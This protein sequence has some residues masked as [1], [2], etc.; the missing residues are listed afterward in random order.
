MNHVVFLTNVAPGPACSIPE[1]KKIFRV[2]D[3]DVAD[4]FHARVQET[5]AGTPADGVGDHL[6]FPVPHM[7][8]A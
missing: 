6:M 1:D 2:T 7:Y 4:V 3:R 5:D 8:S